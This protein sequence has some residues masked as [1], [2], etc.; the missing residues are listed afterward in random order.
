MKEDLWFLFLD[1]DFREGFASEYNVFSV[2]GDVEAEGWEW[3][4][5]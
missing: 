3:I 4:L 2:F 5:E 1:P